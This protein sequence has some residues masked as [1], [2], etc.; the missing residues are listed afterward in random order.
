MNVKLIA[1]TSEPDKVL[2][3]AIRTCYSDK[4]SNDIWNK[5]YDEYKEKDNGHLAL[6]KKIT[7]SQHTSTLEHISFTFSITDIPLSILGHLVRHR[8][9][10]S[11]SV[12]SQRYV[13]QAT[14]SKSKGMNF[15]VPESVHNLKNDE[16]YD[17]TIA[18]CETAQEVYDDLIKEGI[19]AEDARQYLFQGIGTNLIF[20][21]NLRSLLNFYKLRNKNTHSQKETQ[22]LA[23][24][25]REQ[26]ITK[27]EWL[28]DIFN[29]V[30]PKY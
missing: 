1:S 10:T 28:D 9:G 2:F 13:N 14:N 5:E 7:K 8:I 29:I 12:R 24:Q 21:C 25:L 3:T 20:S 16:L 22:E 6:I 4:S 15:I 17:K 19:K 27:I 23:E 11:F 26:V 30:V 18:L